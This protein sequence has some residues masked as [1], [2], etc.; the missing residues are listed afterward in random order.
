[1]V[2]LSDRQ[3]TKEPK[4]E[5]ERKPR[6]P[7]QEP[8]QP[9][10]QQPSYGEMVAKTRELI[11]SDRQLTDGQRDQ[12][13]RFLSYAPGRGRGERATDPINKGSG[14]EICLRYL[15]AI[16]QYRENLDNLADRRI[17]DTRPLGGK[18]GVIRFRKNKGADKRRDKEPT[19]KSQ[20]LKEI[21]WLKHLKEDDNAGFTLSQLVALFPSR[22]PHAVK[23]CANKAVN[24]GHLKYNFRTGLYHL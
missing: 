18:T 24:Q 6:Q 3:L 9:K 19:L 23:V 17:S 13:L 12:A 15:E 22:S 2:A 5:P 1:M 11:L 14:V 7:K 4:Q 20:I 8:K 16:K 21:G 10:Q